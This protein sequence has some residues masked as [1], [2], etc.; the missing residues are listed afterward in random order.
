MHVPDE[1]QRLIANKRAARI[2][3]EEEKK[4]AEKAAK[5]EAKRKAAEA[6][7]REV[8]E[9]N[10]AKQTAV[11]ER[12]AAAIAETETIEK[13]HAS[14]RDALAKKKASGTKWEKG[15]SNGGD[16]A[17][18][19]AAR[20]EPELDVILEAA[21]SKSLHGVNE[22]K[23]SSL[24]NRFEP[25][26]DADA[27]GGAEGSKQQHPS[28]GQNGASTSGRQSKFEKGGGRGH[29]IHLSDDYN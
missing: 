4:A 24:F 1:E 20:A 27:G 8:H 15:E 23:V 13:K 9:A 5:E 19:A 2:K 28:Y 29:S 21:V 26:K 11:K 14:E 22:G 3:A 6:R 17:L 16:D 12:I 18:S 25:K 10:T 7:K